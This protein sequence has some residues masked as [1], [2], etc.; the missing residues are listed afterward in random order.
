MEKRRGTKI[1]IKPPP[2]EV[3]LTLS[4]LLVH[5]FHVV[6]VGIALRIHLPAHG[7]FC[8][9]GGENIIKYDN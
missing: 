5:S 7:R 6:G 2:E 4:H 3:D 9:E 8:G 1:T